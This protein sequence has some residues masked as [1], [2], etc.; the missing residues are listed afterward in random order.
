MPHVLVRDVP[1]DVHARLQARATARGVSLQRFLLEALA[2]VA[3]RAGVAEAVTEWES[4]ARARASRADVS[5]APADL[6]AVRVERA[7]SVDSVT[8]GRRR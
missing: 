4:L 1:A 6:D 7:D 8:S 2:E 5:W 3:E